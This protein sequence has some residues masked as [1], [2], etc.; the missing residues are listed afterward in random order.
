MLLNSCCVILVSHLCFHSNH[1]VANSNEKNSLPGGASLFIYPINRLVT[2]AVSVGRNLRH[3]VINSPIGTKK[4]LEKLCCEIHLIKTQP[5]RSK[6]ACKKR[7]TL[8]NNKP[9]FFVQRL[10]IISNKC[11]TDQICSLHSGCYWLL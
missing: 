4:F 2:Y 3:F 7:I 1:N 10:T 9:L 5:A 6:L 11:Y 8:L